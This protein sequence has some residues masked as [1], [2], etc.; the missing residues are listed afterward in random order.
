MIKFPDH[1][2]MREFVAVHEALRR[3]GF[4]ANNIFC[5]AAPSGLY[6]GALH[7]FVELRAQERVFYT[8]CGPIGM[9]VDAFIR[10]MREVMQS[11]NDGSIPEAE[12]QRV[13]ERSRVFRELLA[14]MLALEAKGFVIPRRMAFCAKN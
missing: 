6:G 3:F 8:D 4:E 10:C 12:L 9:T 7:C 13:W 5:I 14:F 2:A 1:L 11:I